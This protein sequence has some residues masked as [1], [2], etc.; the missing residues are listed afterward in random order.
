MHFRLFWHVMHAALQ[1][2]AVD[3]LH[4][5]NGIWMYARGHIWKQSQETNLKPPPYLS[6]IILHWVP[7]PEPGP[8]TTKMIIGFS[9]A[10]LSSLPEGSA[11]VDALSVWPERLVEVSSYA[12]G[13]IAGLAT[14]AGGVSGAVAVLVEAWGRVSLACCIF[15]FVIQYCISTSIHSDVNKSN[16]A[17]RKHATSSQ[18][19]FAA[20]DKSN[21]KAFGMALPLW[22]SSKSHSPYCVWQEVAMMAARTSFKMCS[23]STAPKLNHLCVDE[24][25][26]ATAGSL[27]LLALQ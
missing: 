5:L 2:S 10:S 11:F 27:S 14:W 7:L 13:S 26:L 22:C 21:I 9:S 20:V 3:E 8:P 18:L 16:L 6:T 12:T 23:T 4:D 24:L 15:A 17:D 19:S 1:S 25:A